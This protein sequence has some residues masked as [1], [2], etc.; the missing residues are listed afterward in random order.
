MYSRDWSSTCALPISTRPAETCCFGDVPFGAVAMFLDALEKA[1]RACGR[2]RELRAARVRLPE[3]AHTLL[4]IVARL[5]HSLTGNRNLDG[6]LNRLVLAIAH[7]ARNVPVSGN[8]EKYH[9]SLATDKRAAQS[10]GSI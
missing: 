10:L 9:A 5:G 4:Q 7:I 1:A 6:P 2:V 8:R 3:S